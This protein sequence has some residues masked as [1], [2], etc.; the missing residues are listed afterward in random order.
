MGRDKDS[1]RRLVHREVEV[2]AVREVTCW[3]D[4]EGKDLSSSSIIGS[5]HNLVIELGYSVFWKNRCRTI[6]STD[7][8]VHIG[9]QKPYRV[10]DH[11]SGEFTI[12]RGRYEVR[13][14][15]NYRIESRHSRRAEEDVAIDSKPVTSL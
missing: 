6:K 15:V 1:R 12:Q 4:V 5:N 8:G 3:L 11:G 7:K 10:I 14:V 2:E 9:V 13:N